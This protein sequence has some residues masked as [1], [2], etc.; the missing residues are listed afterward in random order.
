LYLSIALPLSHI[1]P[2]PRTGRKAWLIDPHLKIVILVRTLRSGEIIRQDVKSIGLGSTAR[3]LS[4]DI[5][6]PRKDKTTTLVGQHLQRQIVDVACF[7]LL[8]PL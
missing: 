7:A 3:D 1:E 2:G 8:T 6:V 5:V 4:F